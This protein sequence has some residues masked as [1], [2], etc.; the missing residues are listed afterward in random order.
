MLTATNLI[1]R[2]SGF[3]VIDGASLEVPK[4]KITACVGPNGAGKSTLVGLLS[5]SIRPDA[6]TI[7]LDGVEV[8]YR[9]AWFRAGEGLR[10]TFQNTTGIGEMTVRE[11]LEL[12]LWRARV[13]NQSTR[14]A[15]SQLGDIAAL[16]G[17]DAVIDA[18]LY[19]LP[20]GV[21]RKVGIGAAMIGGSSYLLLDEP[22]AGTEAGDRTMLLELFRDLAGSGLGIMWIEHDLTS[23]RRT[24]EFLLVVDKGEVIARGEVE[25]VVADPKVQNAYWG[26]AEIG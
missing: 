21:Q 1:K 5:G 7:L 9:P 16:L 13:S 17:L 26:S 22:L 15:A 2:F 24:A 18:T 11:N 4:G 14:A 20:L 19:T 3:T 6:G 12:G 10:R 8:T 25:A 23:V